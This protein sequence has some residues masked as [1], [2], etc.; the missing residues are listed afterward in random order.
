MRNVVTL[1]DMPPDLHEWLKQ[2]AERLTKETGRKTSLYNVVVQA[3]VEYRAKVEG[4]PS[5]EKEAVSALT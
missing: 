3:C 4:T 5:P 2:E 1:S